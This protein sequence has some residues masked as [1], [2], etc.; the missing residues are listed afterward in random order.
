MKM[1]IHMN[2][3]VYQWDT[4]DFH[5]FYIKNDS[6]LYWQNILFIRV[7]VVRM[8]I[9]NGYELIEIMIHFTFNLGFLLHVKRV[10]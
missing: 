6:P 4:A 10:K 8:L 3:K 2:H 7:E 5:D 9:L 1:T